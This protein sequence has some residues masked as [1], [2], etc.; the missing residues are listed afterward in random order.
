MRDSLTPFLY[1]AFADIFADVA[2]PGPA[3][4]PATGSSPRYQIYRSA[5]Q[6][7]IA[8]AAAEEKFWEAF[9]E[10]IELP[11]PLRRDRD[12]PEA[13]R[14]AVAQCLASRSAADWEALFAG[15]DVC[16]AVVRNVR[17][18]MRDPEFARLFDAQ[19]RYGDSQ[20]PALPLPLAADCS[21]GEAMRDAP[22]LGQDNGQWLGAA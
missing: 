7:S 14:R 1:E 16:C 17:E 2:E 4:S 10:L 9:C 5:D 11:A 6:R 13:T 21:V 12:D 8:V 22:T 15:R 19:V 18:A 20:M 3:Y